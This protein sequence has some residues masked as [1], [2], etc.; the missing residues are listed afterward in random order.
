VSRRPRRRNE[1]HRRPRQELV[2]KAVVHNDR[3][4]NSFNTLP[5]LRQ[6]RPAQP[7]LGERP[8]AHSRQVE[9]AKGTATQ[10]HQ[11]NC[12]LKFT[13]QSA[14][15]GPT[16][17]IAATRPG[18][19]P[20]VAAS[21]SAMASGQAEIRCSPGNH[22]QPMSATAYCFRNFA[23]SSVRPRRSR[24]CAVVLAESWVQGWCGPSAVS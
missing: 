13:K 2:S 24:A 4:S 5:G 3:K 23:A 1:A 22:H 18:A 20:S 8:G 11:Q 17:P 10:D 9:G 21:A 15:A 14:G 16:S 6:F 19:P 7:T 12:N